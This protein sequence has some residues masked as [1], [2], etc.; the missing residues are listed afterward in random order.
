MN[1]VF[2]ID[3]DNVNCLFFIVGFYVIINFN[4]V[5]VWFFFVLG[6]NCVEIRSIVFCG[7]KIIVGF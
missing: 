7:V 4:G 5:I 1:L 2:V 6:V 3:K